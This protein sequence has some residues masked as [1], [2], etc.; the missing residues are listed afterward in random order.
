MLDHHI[1]SGN[2]PIDTWLESYIY[3]RLSHGTQSVSV[4]KKIEY[5]NHKHRPNNNSEYKLEILFNF[6]TSLWLC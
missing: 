5:E 2:D 4:D 6:T 1:A 3:R